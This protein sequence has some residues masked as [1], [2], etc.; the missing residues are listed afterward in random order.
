MTNIERAEWWWN[1]GWPGWSS[2]AFASPAISGRVKTRFQLYLA[3]TVANLTLV[4]GTTR[5]CRAAPV[6]AQQAAASSSILSPWLSPMLRP[7]SARSG[8]DNCGP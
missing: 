3:A 8:S 6:A 7:I 1:T 5:V 2:W 4:A